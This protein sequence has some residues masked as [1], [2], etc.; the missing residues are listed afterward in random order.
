MQTCSKCS[1]AN[2]PEAIYCYFDG[3]VLAGHD[4]RGGPVAVGAQPFNSPFVFPTGRTCRSFDELALA[5]V[6]EWST[7]CGLLKDGYLESFLG[8]LGRVDLALA[9]KEAAHFPDPERGLDQ[10]LGQLPTGVLA[11]AKLRVDPVEVN[12]GLLDGDHE[13]TF[14]LELENQGSRLLY[15]TVSSNAL[16]LTLGDGAGAAEKHF[17][18]T[19]ENRI[20]VR[21]RPDRFPAGDRPSDAKLLVESN[22]GTSLVVVRAERPV[23]PFPP[24]P[25]VGA[26]KPRQIA[27]KAQANPKEVA[28]LFESGEVERW[29]RANGWTYPVKIPAASGIAAIQ[30]FFEALGVTKAPKVE[31]SRREFTFQADPGAS[32][33][34]SVDITTQEKRPVFA[35]ATST[36]SWLEVG[37]AKFVG[38]VVTLSA[39]VPAVPNRPGELLEAE[40]DVISNGNQRFHVPVTVQVSG[41]RL[42]EPPPLSIDDD[43]EVGDG[44]DFGSGEPPPPPAR[45]EP[46]PELEMAPPPRPKPT[47]RKPAARDERPWWMHAAPA[48]LLGLALLGVVAY[49][50]IWPR[51]ELAG[52]KGLPAIAG[53]RYDP[54][55]LK[56]GK[57]RV[58]VNFN[59]SERFGVVMVDPADPAERTR[60]TRLTAR[61]DG[62][63]NNVV[64]KIDGNEYLFGFETPNNRMIYRQRRL[65][66]P[67]LGYS[68][69]MNFNAERVR[70]T[71]YVQVIPG[72]EG[73]L[74]TVLIYFTATNLATGPRRV[75]IRYMLDT[76]IGKNDGVPFTA[77]GT[78][79]FVTTKADYEGG[80]VPDYLEAVEKPKDAKDPGTIA[81]L[82][83]R[84]IGWAGVEPIE[85]ERVRICRYPN[86]PNMKWDW[87]PEPMGDDSCVA[88]YWPEKQLAPKET[89]HVAFT[90]GLGRLEISDQ[91]AL[92]AP[93]AVQPNREFVV[94]AYVYNAAK[95]QKV[96][97]ELPPELELIG[98]AGQ[99]VE[100]AAERT[101]VFWKVKAR[102]E[103]TFQIE[104]RS[105]GARARPI[106]IQA[107]TK[108][109]F[110]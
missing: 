48:V 29:Y 22:G 107:T 50:R 63:T 55:N 12:L 28:P 92:S 76:Y 19:H 90:Y 17:H 78:K 95:G 45:P 15:G 1:R 40:L 11:D 52:P 6:E 7:A 32:L 8:G 62:G 20:P 10:L 110:G 99:E 68:S 2:P 80:E 30:Q 69:T 43:E 82:G 35:H 98:E 44:F 42:P 97:L 101:Q 77:P 27:E 13:R 61:E 46:A 56:D 14:D 85:P 72:P 73:F 39:T 84:G 54:R 5:C 26:R 58:G 79:G 18:F 37:R 108:S 83:L 103:G 102:R 49:D 93:A 23:T 87:D 86:N 74:D 104:A 91:L 105:G 60:W 34:L 106:T 33:E 96:T 53:P 66:D 41:E 88:V 51:K 59:D 25:L 67:Y 38:R 36:A 70:V 9:A 75:A 57:P 65:P 94:T 89:L 109:I 47:G 81:R 21:V 100:A 4:R 24:G 16:W 71:Q 3:F 64:V 31:I